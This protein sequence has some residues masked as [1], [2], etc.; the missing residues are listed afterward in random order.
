MD[1]VGYARRLGVKVGKR[2][3]FINVRWGSE[4]YLISLG[5]HVSITDTTFATHDGAVW[6]FRGK[7]PDIDLFEPIKV[8]NNVFIGAG[9]VIFSGVTIGDN[10]IV[11]AGSVVTKDIQSNSV[12]AGVPATRIK[13][14]DDYWQ[15][16]KNNVFST[17]SMSSEEKKKFLEK[18]FKLKG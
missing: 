11:G 16:N 6:V 1:P 15:D 13:S 9:C 5:D 10:V 17:K 4:P 3:R 12:I 2:C 14:V 7:H 8:G 18:S